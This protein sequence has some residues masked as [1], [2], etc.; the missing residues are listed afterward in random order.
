MF[1]CAAGL[2]QLVFTL[3]TL[4]VG[5]ASYHSFPLA[6]ILNGLKIALPCAWGAIDTWQQAAAERWE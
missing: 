4:P 3:V 5:I 2:V 1:P 6:V